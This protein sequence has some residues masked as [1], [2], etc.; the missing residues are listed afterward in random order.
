MWF[1][2][3]KPNPKIEGADEVVTKTNYDV[4]KKRIENL[5]N[6]RKVNYKNLYSGIDVVFYGNGAN[7]LE[8]DFTLAPNVDASQIR[9]NFDGAKDVSID[10]QG[11]LIPLSPNPE[12]F[13][14]KPVAYQIIT[15]ERR[16]VTVRYV[17]NEQSQISFVLGEYYKTQP[18][19][20][21]LVLS[22]PDYIV[23][24]P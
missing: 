11:N 17:I 16:D 9:L 18:L 6:Y 5:S 21:N 23:S 15:G 2:G 8:Y 3:A 4:E 14:Q 1:V 19:I 10:E 20:I 7:R 22:Y 12:I 13:Q 24:R